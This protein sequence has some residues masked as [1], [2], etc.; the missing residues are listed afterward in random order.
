MYYVDQVLLP[1][2]D[3]DHDILYLILIMCSCSVMAVTGCLSNAHVCEHI[4]IEV[5]WA[6]SY[7]YFAQCISVC[8][9]VI[10]PIL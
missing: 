2:S 8:S 7:T 5:I 10:I 6:G 1:V 4:F 3:V 9:L